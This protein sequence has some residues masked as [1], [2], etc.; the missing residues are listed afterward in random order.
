MT[1][2]EYQSQREKAKEIVIGKKLK[3]AQKLLEPIG[4][5]VRPTRIDGKG[6]VGTADCKANRINVAIEK[7]IIVKITGIG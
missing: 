2:E 3:E 7:G 1:P 6:L 4:W 5:Y